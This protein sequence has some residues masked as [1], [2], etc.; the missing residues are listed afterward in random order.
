[1]NT[2][3]A[4]FILLCSL[5]TLP[6]QPMEVTARPNMFVAEHETYRQSSSIWASVVS[7][8]VFTGLVGT[9]IAS[10]NARWY[11]QLQAEAER[12]KSD[13]ELAAKLTKEI[14]DKR[15]Q[16][17]A[18]DAAE[19]NRQATR[20]QRL[21]ALAAEV[22]QK[23]GFAAN[24]CPTCLENHPLF[25]CHND[26]NGHPLHGQCHGCFRNWHLQQQHNDCPEC[27]SPIVIPA[28]LQQLWN[29]Q[30]NPNF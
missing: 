28:G 13:R 26:A 22:A 25:P 12:V 9:Q 5:T 8:L 18:L 21:A 27:R 10:V 7:A 2:K 14:E 1:M 17:D 23:A 19:K 6:L 20:A 30:D 24:E 29:A 3:H 15:A 16:Q 4:T 11:K